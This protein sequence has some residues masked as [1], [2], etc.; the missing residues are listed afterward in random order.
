MTP[1]TTYWGAVAGAK[2][3]KSELGASFCPEAV[4]TDAVPV[5]PATWYW[6]R[7]NPWKVA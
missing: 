2:P 1:A 3:T 7:G 5:L 6:L 4:S